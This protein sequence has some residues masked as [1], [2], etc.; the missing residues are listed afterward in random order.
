[1]P[2]AVE[3]SGTIVSDLL[4]TFERQAFVPHLVHKEERLQLSFC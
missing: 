3:S 1:M 2:A 4:N